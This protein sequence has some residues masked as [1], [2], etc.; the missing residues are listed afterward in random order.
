MILY[1]R[2]LLDLLSPL[3]DYLPAFHHMKVITEHGLEDAK[4]E[5]TIQHLLNMTSGIVYPD[6]EIEAGRRMAK[7]VKE[8]FGAVLGEQPSTQEICNLFAEVPLEFH[9]GEDWRYGA[10][11]DVMGAVIEV[12]SGKKFSEFL[13]EEIFEPLGMV[14]TGFY[15]PKEKQDRFEIIY[16]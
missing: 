15:V 14:D 8:T 3:S 9:P 7:R 11:A 12:V 16:I 2:G 5:I 10:S 4:S 1:E 13:Q 6:S